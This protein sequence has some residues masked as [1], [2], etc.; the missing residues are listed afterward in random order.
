MATIRAGARELARRG[1]L[2]LVIIDYAG[3]VTP[4]DP[5][6]PRQEQVAEVSRDAKR[7]AMDLNVPVVLLS[8]LNREVAS[9]GGGQGTATPTLTDLRDSGALEQDADAV[10]LLHLPWDEQVGGMSEWDLH[11]I[12]AK[13]RDGQLGT[14]NLVRQGFIMRIVMRDLASRYH[15]S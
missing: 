5:K 2:G 6:L 3:L 11:V 9:R 1:E 8:Q 4:R 12:V 15:R 10:L 13:N 14:V 7:L